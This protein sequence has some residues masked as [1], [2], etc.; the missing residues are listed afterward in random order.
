MNEMCLA[1]YPGCTLASTAGEINAALLQVC[2]YLDIDLHEIADWNCCGSSSVHAVRPQLAVSLAARNLFKA[3]QAGRD[4]MVMCAGCTNRLRT[5]AHYLRTNATTRRVN[6]QIL[7]DRLDDDLK[8]HHLLDLLPHRLGQKPWQGSLQRPLKKLRYVPYY[9]CQLAMPPEL[10][11]YPRLYG[12]MENVM[13]WLGAEERNWGYTA[14]CCGAF[15]SVARPDIVVPMVTDIMDQAR[16]AGAEC[17]VTACAMCQLNL[18][19]RSAAPE[20][21]LPVFSIVEL[22]AYGL[23]SDDWPAWFKRHLVDPRPLFENRV[24]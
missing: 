3:Q 14:K 13:D 4:L 20:S 6:E 2:R 10:R 5:A 23:G 11:R 19:L 1:Y 24:L 21:R 16:T 18:E 9:G 17:I 8:I 22:L 7:G 12:S 15:L